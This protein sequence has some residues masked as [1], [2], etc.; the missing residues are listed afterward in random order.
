MDFVNMVSEAIGEVNPE[1][2]MDSLSAETRLRE[3]LAL[4][5]IDLIHLLSSITQGLGGRKLPYED[6]FFTGGIM[7]QDISIGQLAEFIASC[8]DTPLAPPVP[9]A[10]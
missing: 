8:A 7:R 9:L 2:G 5:S 3:D 10:M 1:Y 6:L 4:T